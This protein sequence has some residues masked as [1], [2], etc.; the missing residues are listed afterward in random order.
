MNIKNEKITEI[1]F[2]ATYDIVFKEVFQIPEVLSELINCILN[3]NY[4]EHEISIINPEISN[5]INLKTVKLDIRVSILD[6]Y[7]LNLEMQ[8]Y[9][10]PYN[11]FER[12]YAYQSKMV[13]ESL[14][15][16][17]DYLIPTCI[18]IV[19]INYD[20]NKEYP[21]RI[22]KKCVSYY[23]LKDEEGN[24]ILSHQM[25]I[26]DL[27]KEDFC[28]NIKLKKWIKLIKSNQPELLKGEGSS[29]DKAI[30]KI[31]EVNSDESKRALLMSIMKAER[32]HSAGLI[33]ARKEGYQQG[34]IA[35]KSNIAK[36]LIDKGLSIEEV[37][38]ITGLSKK[39]I[40]NLKCHN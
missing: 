7:R 5:F 9:K 35:E 17:D 21:F 16:G 27:T 34:A 39:E 26:I 1:D 33:G 31:L 22:D 28:D 36:R 20:I 32:D 12:I 30:K 23:S 14:D 38:E 6:K 10:R 3:T 37:E 25:I 18:N 13:S 29:M 2:N 15:A 24:N 11:L 4:Q 19:F 40:A 8:K